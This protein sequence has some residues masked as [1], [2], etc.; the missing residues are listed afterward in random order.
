MDR[1]QVK[2]F[3]LALCVSL[4]FFVAGVAVPAAG[5]L[6]L[7]FVPQPVLFWG[8]KYGRI[9]GIG[10]PVAGGLL[11]LLTAGA[12]GA[13][14]Y[15]VLASMAVFLS[16]FLGRGWSIERI[17]AGTALGM[18]A[19]GG[20]VLWVFFGSLAALQRDVE[21]SLRANLNL[22][23][24]IYEKFGLTAENR[25]LVEQRLPQILE[26]VIQI[27]PAVVFAGLAVVILFNIVLLY[28]R[29]PELKGT[30]LPEADIKEWK[31]PDALVWF[32]IAAGFFLF[33]PQEWGVRTVALNALILT[34]LFYFFQGLAI[35]AYYFH[36]MNVPF[37]LRG[38]GYGL[39]VFEQLC[40]ILVVGLGLFDLWGDFR[41]LNHKDLNPTQAT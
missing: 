14:V 13:L 3:F 31:A 29:L 35:V 25:E 18:A 5:V 40:T 34:G 36:R 37:L 8:L 20:A 26:L 24:R 28:R 4:I 1:S 41:R 15:T 10:A 33:V 23:L 2:Y 27:L 6:F 30:L 32:F 11:L 12:D 16:L 22:S 9:I 21:T 17:V 38:L 19:L 7:P 39:I